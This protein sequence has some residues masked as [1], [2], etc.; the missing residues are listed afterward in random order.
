MFLLAI[1]VALIKDHYVGH[2]RHTP[3]TI[4]DPLL[5]IVSPYHH[6]FDAVLLIHW[7]P[8]LLTRILHRCNV[9]VSHCCSCP[10][11]CQTLSLT[12][13]IM[14]I[15]SAARKWCLC[16]CRRC[17]GLSHLLGSRRLFHT[18]AVCRYPTVVSTQC[19]FFSYVQVQLV[20]VNHQSMMFILTY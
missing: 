15:I 13:T 14:Y 10:A 6:C 8:Q 7:P 18:S 4:S 16:L 19:P 3:D 1:V 5:L 17:L 2:Y 9:L 11:T 12:Y 20:M